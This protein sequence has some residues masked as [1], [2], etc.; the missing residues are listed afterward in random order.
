MAKVI[1][2]APEDA[3]AV[4]GNFNGS[5]LENGPWTIVLREPGTIEFHQLDSAGVVLLAGEFTFTL[6]PVR[7]VVG[8]APVRTLPGQARNGN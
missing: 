1:P 5:H 6:T 8:E 4:L 7:H 3:V 2:M